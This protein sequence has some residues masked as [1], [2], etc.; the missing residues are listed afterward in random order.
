MLNAGCKG[1]YSKIRCFAVTQAKTRLPHKT[2]AGNC[3]DQLRS[4]RMRSTSSSGRSKHSAI[5]DGSAP[6]SSILTAASRLVSSLPMR[7]PSPLPISLPFSLPISLPISFPISLPF[8]MP[9]FYSSFCA[10]FLYSSNFSS[11]RGRNAHSM[12]R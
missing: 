1:L 6:L 8:S 4:S 12:K 3:R 9:I 5:K 7:M 2:F 10:H 11:L